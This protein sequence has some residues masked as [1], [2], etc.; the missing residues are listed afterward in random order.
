MPKVKVNAKGVPV[1]RLAGLVLSDVPAE[2]DVTEEQLKVLQADDYVNVACVAE[3]EEEEESTVF[4][5]KAS[6][7]KPEDEE[8][9]RALSK[10]KG[11]TKEGKLAKAIIAGF[12]KA[13]EE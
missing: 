11:N 8:E 4:G 13:D 10:G 9:L 3:A 7:W 5:R 2:M 1:R 12:K 6:E